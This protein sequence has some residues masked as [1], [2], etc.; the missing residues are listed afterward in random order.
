MKQCAWQGIDGRCQRKAR[1][2][3]HKCREMCQY[4]KNKCRQYITDSK[5]CKRLTKAAHDRPLTKDTRYLI[6][7]YHSEGMSSLLIAFML[8]RSPAAVEKIL[9][10]EYN[11][12]GA[13]DEAWEESD[14]ETAETDTS[15]EA[16]L[17]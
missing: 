1:C 12:G 8:N 5:L 2:Q 16:Q 4:P 17:G 3:W 7:L 6:H 14:S 11:A 9:S 15:G 13:S 10:E